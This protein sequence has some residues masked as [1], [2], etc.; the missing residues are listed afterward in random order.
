MPDPGNKSTDLE[1][2]RKGLR[3]DD[4]RQFLRALEAVLVEALRAQQVNSREAGKVARI[5]VDEG[6]KAALAELAL[7][8]LADR[9]MI[10]L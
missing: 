2:V 10:R 6:H 3:S 9:W 5:A 7:L 8:L 4:T 1:R